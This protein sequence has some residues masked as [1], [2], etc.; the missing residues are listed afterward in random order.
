MEYKPTEIMKFLKERKN[1]KVTAFKVVIVLLVP[2]SIMLFNKNVDQKRLIEAQNSQI[3][4]LGEKEVNQKLYLYNSE[5]AIDKFI[6]T[7]YVYLRLMPDIGKYFRYE[8]VQN[9]DSASNVW[10]DK[11]NGFILFTPG[12]N[13]SRKLP[14]YIESEI[15]SGSYIEIFNNKGFRFIKIR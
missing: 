12:D 10:D 3:K 1:I 9:L 11:S 8:E 6:I 7:D 5:T 14:D 15:R 2:L 13:N 4:K